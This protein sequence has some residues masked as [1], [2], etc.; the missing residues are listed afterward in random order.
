LYGNKR[1]GGGERRNRVGASMHRERIR[2]DR[3]T[4]KGKLAR[5]EKRRVCSL[6]MRLG[7]LDGRIKECDLGFG[8]R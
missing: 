5:E 3:K 6:L 1:K 7:D 2:S 4:K 8:T